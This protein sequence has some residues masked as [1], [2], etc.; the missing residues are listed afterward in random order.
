MNKLE[1]QLSM[2]E[3]SVLEALEKAEGKI[4]MSEMAEMFGITKRQVRSTIE[5]LVNLGYAIS[6]VNGYSI[7]KTQLEL[8]RA[9]EHQRKR[10]I[11]SAK[12]YRSLCAM[13]NIK[14]EEIII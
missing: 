11:A 7:I 9:A 14:Q 3:Q 2:T 12:R 1:K 4:S 13:G 5:D 6:N 8:E 10:L